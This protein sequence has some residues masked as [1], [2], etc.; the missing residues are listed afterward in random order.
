MSRATGGPAFP[1]MDSQTVHRVGAVACEGLT[2]PAERDKVY[3]DATTAAASGMTLR[4][5][6]AVH[7]PFTQDDV[8]HFADAA[9]ECI[10]GLLLMKMM[11]HL[12]Y[13]YADA[14]LVERAK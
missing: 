6:L 9:G 8:I 4:D 13:Q 2:D 11:A 10:N 12:R 14:M 5:Y 3:L 7:A 1:I